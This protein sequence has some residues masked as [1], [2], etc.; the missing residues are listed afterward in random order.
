MAGLSGSSD[1]FSKRLNAAMDRARS[2]AA[3]AA[4]SDASQNVSTPPIEHDDVSRRLNEALARARGELP[5][6]TSAA[7]ATPVSAAP[8]S[9]A[10]IPESTGPVGD[11]D[12]VVRNGECISFI[13]KNTC[14][15]QILRPHCAA[16]T[17]VRRLL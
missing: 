1:D 4:G 12:H 14:A 11:G 17:Y 8:G 3:P 13:A 6:A 15:S 7:P 9:A 2:G 16:R 5:P 10:A